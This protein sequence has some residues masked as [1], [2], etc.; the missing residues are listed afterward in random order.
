M[1]PLFTCELVRQYHAARRPYS[2]VH[3]GP[4]PRWSTEVSALLLR[5]S[6]VVAERRAARLERDTDRLTAVLTDVEARAR[7]ARARLA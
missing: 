1:H 2:A 5:R 6:I 4:A 7:T 3:P